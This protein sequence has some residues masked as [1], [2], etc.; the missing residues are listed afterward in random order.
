[1]IRKYACQTDL[2]HRHNDKLVVD[3]TYGEKI[4][5]NL[6]SDHVP[7]TVYL[8]QAQ[9]TNLVELLTQWLDTDGVLTSPPKLWEDE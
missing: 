4:A 5:V 6:S 2:G 1:M 3:L 7:S 8:N 9:V